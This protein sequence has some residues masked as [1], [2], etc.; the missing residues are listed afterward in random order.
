MNADRRRI[1]WDLV[2]DY[3]AEHMEEIP[4]QKRQKFQSLNQDEIAPLGAL[5]DFELARRHLSYTQAAVH[6]GR[7]LPPHLTDQPSL[8]PT[9][10]FYLK[11][12]ERASWRAQPE[13]LEQLAH[14]FGWNMA[15]LRKVNGE[16]VLESS[17]LTDL[18]E[19]IARVVQ[20]MTGLD[21]DTQEMIAAYAANFVTSVTSEWPRAQP[22]LA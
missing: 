6:I 12:K 2:L 8:A 11:K 19:P 15:W 16:P 14:G 4:T 10:L 5:V 22:S 9:T 7:S 18:P 17:E 21:S 13:S 3:M 20:I 1:A